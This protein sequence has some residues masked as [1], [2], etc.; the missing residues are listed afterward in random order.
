MAKK[1]YNFFVVT[2]PPQDAGA[3]AATKAGQGAPAPKSAPAKAAPDPAPSAPGAAEP[4]RVADLPV[5]SMPEPVFEAPVVD[6]TAFD[7]I[8]AAARI[9]VPAHGY[10]ILKVA[11]MLKSEHLRDLPQDVRRRSVLVALDAAGVPV[12]EVVEDAVQRDRALDAYERVLEKSVEEARARADAENRRLEEEINSRIAELR[13]R[14]DENS[15]LALEE[16]ASL[17]AWRAG[18]RAE[19]ARIAE[20]VGYFVTENPVTTTAAAQ[21]PDGG[22]DVRKA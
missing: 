4:R 14:I 18:K 1:W 10:T 7:D 5:Q 15:R 19:E 22:D 16:E 9:A 13:A 20:A 3:P 12:T 2:E 11:D 21:A 17:T 8:Y 6:P